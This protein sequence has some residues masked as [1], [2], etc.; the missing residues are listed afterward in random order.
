MSEK[1]A[2]AGGPHEAPLR[3]AVLH[4]QDT[5]QGLEGIMARLAWEIYSYPR[6]KP[7]TDEDDAGE[8]YLYF[9]PRLRRLLLR[10]RDRGVPFEHYFHSVLYWNWKSYRR[11]SRRR[12]SRRCAD[13]ELCRL[14]DNGPGEPASD[15]AW[16][17]PPAPPWAF[18]VDDQGMISNGAQRRRFLFLALRHVR[19]LTPEA[20]GRIARLTGFDRGWIESTARVLRD[21]LGPKERRMRMFQQRRNEALCRRHLLER[22]LRA[23]TDADRR[24]N[25][26]EQIA[27]L[28]RRMSAASDVMSRISLSPTHEAIAA[29]LGIP[30]G[31]VD[32]GLRWCRLTVRA[33]YG[34]ERMRY[35]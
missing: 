15:P 29:A 20:V 27:R 3:D 5:G 23:E 10:Y 21:E 26:E 4:Y 33:L 6:G 24:E 14:A 32:T 16:D 17:L 1:R 28:S 7:G 12:M 19:L 22:E 31:T 34:E 13:R 35:A 11:C 9:Y 18:Q 8:F 30:K 25:L 2:A